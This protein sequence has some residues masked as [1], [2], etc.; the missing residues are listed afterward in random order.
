ME[1][2]A[3]VA[4]RSVLRVKMAVCASA[5]TG[6]VANVAAGSVGN[7]PPEVGESSPAALPR[8]ASESDALFKVPHYDWDA[9]EMGNGCMS[10]QRWDGLGV[11]EMED[12]WAFDVVFDV[13]GNVKDRGW[14]PPV[15]AEFL[16]VACNDWDESGHGE[17]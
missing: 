8:T 10:L 15:F 13:H 9:R 17:E 1:R 4:A 16:E 14:Y 5:G 7:G 6:Q 11:A 2:G 3:G 12:G